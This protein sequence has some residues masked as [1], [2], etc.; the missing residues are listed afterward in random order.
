MSNDLLTSEAARV[1]GVHPDTLKR[2]AT[3]GAVPHW[4]TPG[5]QFRFKREDI[6]AITQTNAAEPVSADSAA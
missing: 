2:W 5:G 3:K 1:I 6:E 4:K